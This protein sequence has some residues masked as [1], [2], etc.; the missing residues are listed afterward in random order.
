ML[1]FVFTYSETY[2]PGEFE[3]EYLLEDLIADNHHCSDLHEA[4]VYAISLFKIN[5]PDAFRFKVR[6]DF[7]EEEYYINSDTEKWEKV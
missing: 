4:K 1:K 7:V 6:L 5:H 3:V 2:V